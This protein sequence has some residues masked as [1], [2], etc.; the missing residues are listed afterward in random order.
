MAPECSCTWSMWIHKKK[1]KQFRAFFVVFS[2]FIKPWKATTK[3]NKFEQRTKWET[4]MR[5]EVEGNGGDLEKK[6]RKKYQKKNPNNCATIYHLMSFLLF[7]YCFHVFATKI[8]FQVVAGLWWLLYKTFKTKEEIT[9]WAVTERQRTVVQLVG[10]KWNVDREMKSDKLVWDLR[11]SWVF[12]SFWCFRR[13]WRRR[14][15]FNPEDDARQRRRP[16][17]VELFELK[18]WLKYFY[19]VF[20]SVTLC[21]EIISKS[22]HFNY[23]KIYYMRNFSWKEKINRTIFHENDKKFKF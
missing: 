2:R 5:R 3:N 20:I 19:L 15:V 13:K 10:W 12:F 16:M 14:R 18:T 8:Q 7:L 21:F 6:E 1:F 22:N 4:S 9:L 11:F 23:L 17:Y